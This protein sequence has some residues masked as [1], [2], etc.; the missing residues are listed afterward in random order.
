MPGAVPTANVLAKRLARLLGIVSFDPATPTLQQFPIQPGDLDDIAGVMTAAL[1]ETVSLAPTEI[2][3]RDIGDW[4]N[5]P[6]KVSLNC[7]QGSTVISGLTPYPNNAR[8]V[9]WMLGCTIN[10]VGDG[11][12]NEINTQ[13]SLSRPFLGGTG[14]TTA[15][16]YGDCVQLDDSIGE[17]LPP[18][19]I[20]PQWPLIA[21][22]T[23]EQFMQISGYPLVT[24]SNGAPYG[25]PGWW[26][27]QK[28]I[29]RP[30][31]WF[32]DSYYDSASTY[33]P[34]RLR[35]GPMPDEFYSLAYRA[36]IN[37]IRIDT[38]DIDNV[39]HTD[40]GT[41]IPI[42]NTWVESLYYPICVK[43][44]TGL[45]QFR[46]AALLPEV[47]RRYAQAVKNMQSDGFGQCNVT[48]GTYV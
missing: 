31:A 4:L 24:D 15:T 25:W 1:Q 10:I 2:R 37:P 34:R 45:P 43:L 9:P 22:N 20:P 28:A 12:N 27:T 3:N 41:V 8:G 39:G 36:G 5:A 11:Y 30:V 21:A 16:V 40:P 48:Q 13:T 42:P 29:G 46:N 17:I 14:A 44:M 26:F 7:T 33:L 47:Q 6:T 38:T 19:Q 23:R 32:L 18:I 35:V